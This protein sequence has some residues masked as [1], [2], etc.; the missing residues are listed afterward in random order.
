MFQ[1]ITG[2]CLA[3]L[4]VGCSSTS[5][6]KWASVNGSSYILTQADSYLIQAYAEHINVILL[7]DKK[8][9]LMQKQNFIA[10]ANNKL[11]RNKSEDRN[12]RSENVIQE[13]FVAWW[14][15]YHFS[16]GDIGYMQSFV[17]KTQQ[18]IK[19]L[20]IA[21]TGVSDVSLKQSDLEMARA[22]VV[23]VAELYYC[24][25]LGVNSISFYNDKCYNISQE[26]ETFKQRREKVYSDYVKYQYWLNNIEL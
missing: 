18:S 10:R 14:V 3:I 7:L 26:E 21:K 15:G 24:E 19:S 17:G 22:L 13:A 12:L 1:K 16:D 20:L 2:L 23:D 8:P 5:L 4:I 6:N 25:K 11:I 9:L